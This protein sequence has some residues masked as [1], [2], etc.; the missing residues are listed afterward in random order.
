[1]FEHHAKEASPS[2]RLISIL[3]LEPCLGLEKARLTKQTAVMC[4]SMICQHKEP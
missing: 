1:M 4:F 2:A 3:L